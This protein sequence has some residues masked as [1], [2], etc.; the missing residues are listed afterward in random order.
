MLLQT[1][2]LTLPSSDFLNNYRHEF[3]AV[4]D[5][6]YYYEEKSD[7]CLKLAEKESS[8]QQADQICLKDKGYLA[9]LYSMELRQLAK[10][11]L[12]DTG[13]TDAWINPPFKSYEKYAKN[14]GEFCYSFIF[15]FESI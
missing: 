5:S 4:S 13:I 1:S 7:T 14:H 8:H 9:V 6:G 15:I 3:T 10:K 2:N 11:I 12:Q